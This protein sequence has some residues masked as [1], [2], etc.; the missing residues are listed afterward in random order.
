M[1]KRDREQLRASIAKDLLEGQGEPSPTRELLRQY[2]PLEGTVGDPST[3]EEHR[4]RRALPVETPWH[5]VPPWHG[6]SVQ[7]GTVPR[8]HPMPP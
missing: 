7:H 8:R 6:T 2:A 3:D 4:S 1:N 5:H